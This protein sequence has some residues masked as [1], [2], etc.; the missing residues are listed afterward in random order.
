MKEVYLPE[1]QNDFVFAFIGNPWSLL[2][3][4]AVAVIGVFLW[5]RRK[6]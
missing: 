1:A 6:P 5:K 2:L 4:A 3:F